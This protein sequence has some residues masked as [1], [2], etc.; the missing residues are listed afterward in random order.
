MDL[1]AYGQNV[2]VEPIQQNEETWM[3]KVLLSPYGKKL[4]VGTIVFYPE[5]SV[6]HFNVKDKIYHV[7]WEQRIFAVGVNSKQVEEIVKDLPDLTL[8]DKQMANDT[9]RGH[10]KKE[11]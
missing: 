9:Y 10:K 3:G 6:N 4:A 11:D 1:I 5:N 8:T 7:I 2:T